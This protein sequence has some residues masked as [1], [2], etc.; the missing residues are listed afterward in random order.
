MLAVPLLSGGTRMPKASDLPPKSSIVRASQS[1]HSDWQ[2]PINR[3]L[4]CR[5]VTTKL[6]QLAGKPSPPPGVGGRSRPKLSTARGT[7]RSCRRF[8]LRLFHL[9]SP[10]P[11]LHL[12][13]CRFPTF[14]PYRNP[15]PA[16]PNRTSRM[17][18][19]W[20][21]S[22]VRRGR[23]GWAAHPES[24]KDRSP[25]ETLHQVTLSRGSGSHGSR[26]PRSSGRSSWNAILAR[27]GTADDRGG[28]TP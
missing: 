16:Q 6:P 12:L 3:S 14:I 8:P 27:S 20:W 2:S 9:K 5:P 4:G 21:W 28:K 26:S 24:E 17:N 11:R 19:G 10:R 25:N 1:A 22:G 18:W 15:R 7:A 13:Q 23:S